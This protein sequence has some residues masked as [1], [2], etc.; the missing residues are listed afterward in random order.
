MKKK[1][2]NQENPEPKREYEKNMSEIFHKKETNLRKKIVNEKK[3][4]RKTNMRNI[5]N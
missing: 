1:K 5:T 3:N 4:T 2:K